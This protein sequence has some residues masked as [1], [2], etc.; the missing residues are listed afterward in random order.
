MGSWIRSL[1]SR[2]KRM[3]DEKYQ[4]CELN[5]IR[6]YAAWNN[7]PKTV[8]NALINRFKSTPSTPR[9]DT[10]EEDGINI[11]LN[12]PYVGP[13]GD[14]FLKCFMKKVRRMLKNGVKVNFKI[15]Y[16][17]THLSR[18]TGVKDRTPFLNRSNVVYKITCPGCGS[19][20]VGKT[21]RYII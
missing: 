9:E 15:R 21:D 1:I 19:S 6:S 2:V 11:W 7:F 13:R 12:F 8:R 20:Y 4:K 10:P 16:Q 14:S 17:T 3:V 5:A 18:F